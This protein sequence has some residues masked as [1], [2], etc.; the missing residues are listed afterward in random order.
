[1]GAWAEAATYGEGA[2]E[3]TRSIDTL[4]PALR[5]SRGVR[6]ASIGLS[7]ARM[8]RLVR[9]RGPRPLASEDL[10]RWAQRSRERSVGYERSR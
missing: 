1:M 6:E 3:I 8:I 2:Q 9:E 10:E 7:E 4:Y 5:D